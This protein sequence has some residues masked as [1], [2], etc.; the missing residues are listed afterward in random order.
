MMA[1]FRYHYA[2]G[3]DAYA[4]RISAATRPSS[5]VVKGAIGVTCY[6]ARISI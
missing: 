1:S 6:I 3:Y 5:E 2:A 4:A